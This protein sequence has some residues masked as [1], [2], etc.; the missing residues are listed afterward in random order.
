LQLGFNH[1]LGLD[2]NVK[3]RGFTGI[4]KAGSPMTFEEM[5]S[6]GLWDPVWIFPMSGEKY[7][8]SSCTYIRVNAKEMVLT[9]ELKTRYDPCQLCV[10]D[11][12]PIG[13]YVY[14]F[15]E[16]G[17]VYH[18][19]SCRQVDRYAVEINKE[20]AVTKGYGPCSRCGGG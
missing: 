15:T 16:G 6:E 8:S 14:C 1:K 12:I 13:S 17:T 7:H 5:E 20:E 18:E 11:R 3:C 19:Y 9:A 2:N 10:S 4:E